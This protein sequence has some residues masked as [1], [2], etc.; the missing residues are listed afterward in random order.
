MAKHYSFLRRDLLIFGAIYHDI[1]KVKELEV[2]SEIK[3]TDEGRLVGHL[4]M[5]CEFVEKFS[6]Q[7]ND[8]PEETKLM[9]KHIVLSHHGKLEYGSPK[10]PKFLEA[11][12][13]SMVDELDSRVDSMKKFMDQERDNGADSWSRYHSQYDRYFFLK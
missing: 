2:S 5:A 6:S 9:C 7:I 13:V 11:L 8:F 3:Y 12:I 1:G 4:T 10:R